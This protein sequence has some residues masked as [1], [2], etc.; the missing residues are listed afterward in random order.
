MEPGPT[1]R[2][3]HWPAVD[4]SVISKPFDPSLGYAATG[5]E[6][7]FDLIAIKVPVIRKGHEDRD[8][9]SGERSDELSDFLLGKASAGIAGLFA[10]KEW[11]T[12]EIGS[13]SRCQRRVS[14]DQLGSRLMMRTA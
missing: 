6:E 4:E 8:I 2:L 5:E 3:D 10:N 13:P 7:L 11:T 12:K 14:R 9:A 1:G